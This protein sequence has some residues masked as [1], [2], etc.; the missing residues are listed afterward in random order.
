MFTLEDYEKM[1]KESIKIAKEMGLINSGVGKILEELEISI[2]TAPRPKNIWFGEV[3][4][5]PLDITIYKDNIPEKFP[6]PLAKLFAQVGTDHETI[7]HA[8]NFLMFRDS[9]EEAACVTEYKMARY[10]GK[11]EES[12]KARLA[13]TLISFLIPLYQRVH[14]GVKLRSYRD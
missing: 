4:Y 2:S 5:S 12:L 3:T 8:G 6:K 11:K 1:K 7:G 10:R 13:W 14:R 9:S